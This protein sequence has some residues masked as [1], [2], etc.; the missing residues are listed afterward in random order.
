MTLGEPVGGGIFQEIT[1]QEIID[2]GGH[3]EV[4]Q[5]SPEGDL[6]HLDP[7][8]DELDLWV[9]RLGYREGS[10]DLVNGCFA[11]AKRDLA[12]YTC[13]NNTA[14]QP[15]AWRLV[16][17]EFIRMTKTIAS[18]TDTH[19]LMAAAKLFRE[20]GVVGASIR[21]IADA[22]GV[23]PG[24]VTYRYP[25]KEAL[26]VA[27]MQRAVADISVRV[28]DAIEVSSD[29]VERLR[30]AMRVHLRTLLDGD[31]AVFVL[32][33]DWQRLSPQSRAALAQERRRYES[34]WEGLIYAAAA[35]G[36]LVEGLDLS[37]VRKFVFGA[38]NSV[39]FWYQA[40]GPRTPEEIADAFSALI[41]LGALSERSRPHPSVETYERLGAL[42]PHITR[43]QGGEDVE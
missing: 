35:S 15:K 1:D 25:T 34:I 11:L 31:D 14:S 32:L 16:D 10:V 9:F 19:V 42:R 21:A 18:D 7:H 2:D 37:L 13:T 3:R 28:F 4:W 12:L 39:A 20:H 23:L 36:Q 6:Y 38:A 22:A 33:F 29:P 41:G 8:D 43:N 26:V 17:V 40:G 24:S 5:Q 30:L 27:L